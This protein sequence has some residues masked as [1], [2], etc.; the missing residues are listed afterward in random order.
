MNADIIN[1]VGS[2]NNWTAN[3]AMLFCVL[4]VLYI[5]YLNR[6]DAMT[7]E[8]RLLDIFCK[9]ESVLDKLSIKIELLTDR[10]KRNRDV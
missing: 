3:A 6:K 4:I 8:N 1:A 5:L 2:A 10:Q 7:R 9:I